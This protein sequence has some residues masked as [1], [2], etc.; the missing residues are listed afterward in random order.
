M[1]NIVGSWTDI[2]FRRSISLIFHWIFVLLIQI[3]RQNSWGAWLH[4]LSSSHQQAPAAV[5]GSWTHLLQPWRLKS[6]M[7]SAP[8]SFQLPSQLFH[9]YTGPKLS[10]VGNSLGHFWGLW[11]DLTAWNEVAMEESE[12]WVHTEWFSPWDVLSPT[13]PANVPWYLI[14][15]ENLPLFLILRAE[16]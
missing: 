13:V 15:I 2:L 4:Q 14:A 1:K 12:S 11:V 9:K 5:A 6:R 7:R 8:Q 10:F 3:S 16:L